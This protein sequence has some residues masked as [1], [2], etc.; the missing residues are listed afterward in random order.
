IRAIRSL[1]A[2]YQNLPGIVRTL[3][4]AEAA[5]SGAFAA[6]GAEQAANARTLPELGMGV[7]QTAAGLLGTRAGVQGYRGVGAPNIVM[8]ASEAA[9]SR[10][11]LPAGPNFIAD[12]S[13]RV[14]PFGTAI[15]MEQA[16]DG[17][18]V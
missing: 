16:P 13:G 15:P 5:S 2:V 1:P 9:Q 3:R 4:A 6:R 8:P 12:A 10:A 17:S 18:Y 11:A 7:A 14:A